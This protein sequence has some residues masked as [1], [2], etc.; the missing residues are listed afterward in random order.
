MI[1]IPVFA[2]DTIVL[3]MGNLPPFIIL[4]LVLEISLL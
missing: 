1:K 4:V 3:L 2:P